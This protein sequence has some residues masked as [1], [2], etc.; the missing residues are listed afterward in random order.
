MKPYIQL[1]LTTVFLIFVLLSGVSL[2]QAQHPNEISTTPDSISST[3]R[4]PWKIYKIAESLDPAKDLG[5]YL[6]LAVRPYDD[7]PMI[8]YYDQYSGALMYAIP[9]NW[10]G[11]CGEDNDWHCIVLD[12][13][14]DVG[15]HTSID[16]WGESENNRKYGVSYYDATNMALKLRMISC[17]NGD[18]IGEN[19]TIRDSD[20]DIFSYGLYTSFKFGSTGVPGIVYYASN[21]LSDDSLQYAYPVSS[22]G[23]C[24]VGDQEG[25]WNCETIDSGNGVGQYVSTDMSWDGQLKIAYYDAGLG[26]LKSANYVGF[27]GNCGLIGGWQCNTI[28]GTDGSNVG[29]N[30]SIQAPQFSGDSL[31][32]AYYDKTNEHL[33]F[34]D[35]LQNW[36]VVVDE[37]G[38]SLSN[39][40]IS[41]DIDK[42]Y[43][44]IIAYQ[45]IDSEFSPPVLRIARPASVYGEDSLGNCGE[46]PP[47]YLFQ[48]WQCNTLD[49][50]GQYT[51]EADYVSLVVKSNGLAMIA[52]TEYDSYYDATRLKIIYQYSQTFLPLLTK[53]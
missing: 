33:K 47:G 37:M 21:S 31:R 35:S 30:A 24:G 44:P 28:D 29:L 6:S 42:D 20:L 22:G 41:M 36:K 9:Y 3:S 39:M 53:P 40:G 7:Y 19:Y 34:Y 38:S 16:V 8:S 18:C 4:Y 13:T 51:E 49:N 23:N 15:L 1:T 27:G 10:S 48:Y 11:S 52:Y 5:L 32:I 46:V 12:Q 26:N 2:S 25:L 45:Q 17:V 14:G 43:S 50:G